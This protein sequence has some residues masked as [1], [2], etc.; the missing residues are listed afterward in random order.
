MNNINIESFEPIV[1]KDF[2]PNEY[3]DRLVEDFESQINN[4]KYSNFKINEHMGMFMHEVDFKKHPELF[5]YLKIKI[6]KIFNMDLKDS[7]GLQY[8]RYSKETGFEPNLR[9]HV[10]KVYKDQ[11]HM[12]SF[13]LSINNN[14]SWPIYINKIKYDLKDNDAL[15]FNVT[16]S[17]HW[18]PKMEFIDKDFFDVLVFRFY[19]YENPIFLPEDLQ[20]RLERERV[21]LFLN[22]YY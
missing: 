3:I 15:F 11:P 5:N 10:D 13:S 9:P 6:K 2:L 12:I 18:R 17:L 1:I 7:S 14:K 21:N 22:Y 20:Q 16:N 8:L 19:D 4:N